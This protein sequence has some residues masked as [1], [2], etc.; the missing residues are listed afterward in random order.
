M[1]KYYLSW[2]NKDGSKVDKQIFTSE[3]VSHKLQELEQS[4]CASIKI[5]QIEKEELV[6]VSSSRGV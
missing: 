2:T 6:K 1:Y 3:H 5:E 4:K